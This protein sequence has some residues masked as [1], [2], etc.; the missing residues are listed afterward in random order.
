MRQPRLTQPQLQWSRNAACR[1]YFGRRRI[2]SRK[3]RRACVLSF[4]G[5]PSC[6]AG[7]GKAVVPSI[8][9]HKSWLA[10]VIVMIFAFYYARA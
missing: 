3:N 4:E 10:F 8:D 7:S 9:E 6:R 2:G 1:G 5:V